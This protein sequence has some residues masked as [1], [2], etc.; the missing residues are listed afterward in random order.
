M[1]LFLR[2]TEEHVWVGGDPGTRDTHSFWS[3]RITGVR[4]SMGVGVGIKGTGGG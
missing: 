4:R 3:N 2:A 1:P